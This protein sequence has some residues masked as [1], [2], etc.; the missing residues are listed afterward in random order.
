MNKIKK[1]FYERNLQKLRKKEIEHN[2]K[3]AEHTREQMQNEIC[4]NK[5]KLRT[6]INDYFVAY[7]NKKHFDNNS[8]E[9][10]I[11]KHQINSLAITINQQI[12]NYNSFIDKTI[13][14]LNV[15]YEPTTAEHL[16]I[17]ASAETTIKNQIRENIRAN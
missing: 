8:I 10:D 6:L 4:H 3:I 9:T 16:K 17:F 1:Y 15:W 5:Q 2:A 7:E 13:N 11:I 14:T 12:K